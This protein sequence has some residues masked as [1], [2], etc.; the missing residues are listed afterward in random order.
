MK[1]TKIFLLLFIMSCYFTT[2]AE[3]KLKIVSTAS[4]IYDMAKNITG[5]LAVNEVIVPIGGD[6]HLYEPKPSDAKMIA[7]ADLLLINALTFEGWILDLIKNS[8]ANAAIDTVTLGIDAIASSQYENAYDPHAW[9]DVSLALVYIRNIK[10]AVI[11]LDPNNRSVYEKNYDNYKAKLLDLDR[12]IIERI[13][14]IPK[15]KRV[16]ITTHDAFAYYGRR[17]G[18]KLEALMGI[19]TESDA[20]AADMRRVSE[21]I[22][23]FD[24]PALFVE[25]TISPKIV[26]QIA[27]DNNISIGG[28][29]FTDSIGG[30]ETEGNSYYDMMKHNT[31]TI[32]DALTGK[33]L[34]KTK[35][36]SKSEG[37]NTWLYALVILALLLLLIPL[38][39][40]LN[41]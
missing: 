21:A 11:A 20:T 8:G 40:K 10:D 27:K 29:L 16:I 35:Y 24:V 26:E 1:V 6:P 22:K 18:L 7:E 15:D 2:Q 38:I 23:S 4:M 41:K 12:Y 14:E 39:L 30:P 32:V 36:T 3:E 28:E 25:S 34:S 31:D 13:K 37:S 9:M 19:S 17:Y 33:K 5:D